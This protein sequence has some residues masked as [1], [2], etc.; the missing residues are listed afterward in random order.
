MFTGIVQA[1]GRITARDGAADGV[2]VRIDAA[3]LGV[4]EIAVGDSIAVGGCCLTVVAIDAHVLA[5]DVSAETL[6]CT[7]GFDVGREVNLEKSLRLSDRLGGHL[8]SG[9]VDGVGVVAAFA[10]VSTD[11]QGSWYLSIDAPVALA[12]YIASK[13][14]IAVDGVSLTV[15]GVDGAR[16]TVN[17]IPHTLAAT[18]LRQLAVGGPVN[19][20]V[21]VIARYV[22]RLRSAP[23]PLLTKE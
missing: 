11:A 19:L 18:T 4:A 23:S 22:E 12:R 10:P 13:G 21:D 6:A 7:A 16:F 5:F 1:T 15:N 3:A 9:H 8:V 20:E 14:S 2:R 17:L